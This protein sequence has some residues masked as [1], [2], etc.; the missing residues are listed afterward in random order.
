MLVQV[1][2]CFYN[3]FWYF[4]HINETFDV[5]ISEEIDG[6]KIKAYQ[7]ISGVYKGKEIL[8]SDTINIAEIRLKKLK[9]L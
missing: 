7:V 5:K 4:E 9:S 6:G 1:V 3:L 8:I 2:T